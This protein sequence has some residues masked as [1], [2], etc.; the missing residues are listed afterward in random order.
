MK[1][2]K[3]FFLLLK[4]FIH[5]RLDHSMI[6]K[7]NHLPLFPHTNFCAGGCCLTSEIPINSEVT[8]RN[9]NLVICLIHVF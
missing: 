2:Q 4:F 8:Q 1:H 9:E 7:E 6:R 5:A 3:L